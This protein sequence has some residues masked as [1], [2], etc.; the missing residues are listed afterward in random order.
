MVQQTIK[1][2]ADQKKPPDAVATGRANIPP[3]IEVPIIRRI[4]PKNFPIV[5]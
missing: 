1:H 2:I 4:L 3:P 5:I